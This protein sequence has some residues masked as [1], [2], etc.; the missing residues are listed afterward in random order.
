MQC[1]VCKLNL[2]TVYQLHLPIYLRQAQGFSLNTNIIM[3][4]ADKPADVGKYQMFYTDR[5]VQQFLLQTTPSP[6]IKAWIF[7]NF[8]DRSIYGIC[9]DLLRLQFQSSLSIL[10]RFLCLY[11]SISSV[12]A[13]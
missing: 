3:F 7:L 4:V 6:L 9:R 13:L 1:V 5:K 10:M 11:N 8:L 12:S 2:L